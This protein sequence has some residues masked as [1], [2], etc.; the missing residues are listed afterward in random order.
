MKSGRKDLNKSARSKLEAYFPAPNE[1]INA[2]FS[3]SRKA[4][5]SKKPGKSIDRKKSLAALKAKAFANTIFERIREG[6]QKFP[7]I[8]KQEPFYLDL[9]RLVV[10]VGRLKQ[11]LSVLNASADIIRK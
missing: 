6:S 9:M 8:D 1:I 11:N 5:T 7:D 2:G 3:A 4:F 10:D